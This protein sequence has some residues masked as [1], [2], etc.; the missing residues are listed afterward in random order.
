MSCII[1]SLLP[2]VLVGNV[3]QYLC[4]SVALREAPPH[5]VG[6]S[7]GLHTQQVEDHGV[8]QPELGLQHC[9]LPLDDKEE[10]S[11]KFMSLLCCVH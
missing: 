10:V 11:L 4:V 2:Q 3:A 6:D 7:E 9:G 1:S 8:G 5:H